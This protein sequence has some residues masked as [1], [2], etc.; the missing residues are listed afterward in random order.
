[1]TDGSRPSW[2]T[3]LVRIAH[4]VTPS[5]EALLWAG[6]AHL[7]LVREGNRFWIELQAGPRT[8]RRL[9]S[10][11]TAIVPWNYGIEYVLDVLRRLVPGSIE[12]ESR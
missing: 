3:R 1:M 6:A 4:R 8:R 9:G 7:R 5:E 10:I 11:G 12:G 2:L